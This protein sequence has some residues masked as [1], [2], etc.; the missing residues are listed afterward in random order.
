MYGQ[1]LPAILLF[2]VF[3]KYLCIKE[4]GDFSPDLWWWSDLKITTCCGGLELKSTRY[5]VFCYYLTADPF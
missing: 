4:L 3:L 1:P 5:G 2:S